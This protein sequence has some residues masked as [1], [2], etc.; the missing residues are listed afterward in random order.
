M[1]LLFLTD[2]I[3]GRSAYSKVLKSISSRLVK[4]HDVS[5]VPMG[6][7]LK[8]IPFMSPHTVM[9]VNVYG[10]GNDPF[11]EDVAPE[12][13]DKLN[14]DM[15]I[16]IKEPW[17]FNT[18]PNLALNYVPM[19]IIDHTPLSPH[20]LSRVTSG[21]KV[22]A[23]SRFGQRELKANKV[24]SSY[25]PHGV[26]DHYEC[27]WD[28][29]DECAKTWFLDPDAFKIGIVAMNRARKM[30]PRM[31]RAI[32]VF[33]DAN[34]D[35][36]VQVMFWGSISGI[37][38]DYKPHGVG[39]TGASLI[40]EIVSLDLAETIQW[41]DE[42]AI[43]EGIPER[44]PSLGWDMVSLYNSFDVLLHI[45]GGE[46][47]GLPL[48]EAQRCGVP[49][50]TTDY[51]AGPENVGI[52]LTVPYHD[53]VVINSVGTRYALADIDATADALA[54]IAN[55][56]KD[57]LARKGVRFTERYRWD[58][59]MEKHFN[60]FLEEC[61]ADLYPFMSTKGLKTWRDAR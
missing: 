39:D 45:T 33:M 46:G 23:V 37:A 47:F 49:V 26:E 48:I 59:I 24:D 32:R 61:E 21:F 17:N 56:D 60:P 8:G 16:T 35:I 5:A 19:A 50:I 41:P 12:Y 58:N 11:G 30:L 9:G 28:K 25:I 42:N 38:M 15:L 18:I 14:A 3:W 1:K 20:L 6:L 27:L 10:S 43:N 44:L 53:Y 40:Q 29:K 54:K 34:P 31:F 13:Y 57:K 7:A 55:A 36:K 52:G 4:N 22:I 51:A 2:R